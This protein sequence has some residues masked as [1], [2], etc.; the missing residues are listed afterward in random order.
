MLV[1]MTFEVGL[2]FAG[3]VGW[4]V[5]KLLFMYVEVPEMPDGVEWK[6]ESRDKYEPNPDP[7]CH[8]LD[9]VEYVPLLGDGKVKDE[10]AN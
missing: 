3:S 5:G 9:E 8:K 1:L 6:E 4:G 7:C 10:P 2:L